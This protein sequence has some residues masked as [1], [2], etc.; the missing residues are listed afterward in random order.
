LGN[1]SKEMRD[2]GGTVL[3]RGVPRRRNG[4]IEVGRARVWMGKACIGVECP[5]DENIFFAGFNAVLNA[6]IP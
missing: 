1:A 5:A 4:P 2:T 6:A 3:N